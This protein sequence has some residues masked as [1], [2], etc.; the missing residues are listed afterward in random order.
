M[1]S[2]VEG[3]ACHRFVQ[4]FAHDLRQHLR[5]ISVA[6]QRIQRHGGEALDPVIGARLDEV[7][8]AVQRQEQLITS[9]V[10]YGEATEPPTGSMMP[11]SLVLQTAC[12]RVDE[13]RKA[14]E[15]AIQMPESG[16]I[17]AVKIPSGLAKAFE[18]ILHNGLKFCPAGE[19]PK[20]TVTID[21]DPDNA[22]RI[23][24]A[25][26]GVG[27]EAAY[28]ERVFE[29]FQKLQ[30]GEFP[31]TGMGLSIAKNMIEAAGGNIAIADRSDGGRGTTVAVEIPHQ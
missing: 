12:L 26:R 22:V 30:P 18:K 16:N 10:D 13:F 14:R 7:L 1:P 24:F 15:G 5:A 25:D 20:L 17:P 21:D 23:E 27:I 3:V 11:L 19:Q 4:A 6:A 29:P 9:A 31:G 28:R 8:S 2:S